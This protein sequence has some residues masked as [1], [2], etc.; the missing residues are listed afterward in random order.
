[1]VLFFK[2]EHFLALAFATIFL[3]AARSAL[4]ESGITIAG[5]WVMEGFAAVSGGAER[6][7][8]GA[9]TL[10][11][12]AT[13]DLQKLGL[14][15]G[16]IYADLEDHAGRDPDQLVGDLQIFDKLNW[17]PYLQTFELWYQQK[18]FGDRLRI[19]LGKMDANSE[20]SVIDN[21]LDF[22]DSSTQVTPTLLGFTTT[23][24]PMPTAAVFYTPNSLFYADFSFA[25]AGRSDRFLVFSGHPTAIEPTS[26]GQLTIAEGGLTW[27][28]IPRVAA[29]GNLRLGI[30]R[31]T[32]TF[33]RF[34]GGTQSGAQ[35]RYAIFDQTLWQPAGN[36]DNKRGVRGFLEYGD[37]E[38]AVSPI[39]RHWGA[40]IAWTGPNQARALDVT[41]I[42]VQDAHISAAAGL[43]DRDE[44]LLESFY[45]LQ[46]TNWASVQPDVQYIEHPGGR[47]ANAL[48]GIVALQIT[49]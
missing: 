43:P 7:T 49:L 9:S 13:F 37:T 3:G 10:D 15:G 6:G 27:D 18:L 20:F 19:K 38:R 28:R 42:T 48:I 1:M 22:L 34:G 26:G 25:E 35:G 12:N 47:Y 32:G 11:V 41:G 2:K 4:A 21:G 33:P 5:S 8:V 24:S 23:P 36:G 31:N 45:K 40:G 46:V 29:D 30:W 14:D 39:D 16:E 44:L 17:T